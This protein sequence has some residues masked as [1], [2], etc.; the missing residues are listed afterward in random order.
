MRSHREQEKEERTAA[1]WG[2]RARSE[3]RQQLLL[4]FDYR[5]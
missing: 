4:F 3:S 5:R 2:R 1:P